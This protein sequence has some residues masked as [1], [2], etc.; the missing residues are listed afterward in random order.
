[1]KDAE[2]TVRPAIPGDGEQLLALAR[3]LAAT[4]GGMPERLT[5]EWIAANMLAADGTVSVHVAELDGRLVGYVA[6]SRMIETVYASA[7][8]YVSDLLVTA[9][10]RGRGIGRQLLAA[11][12]DHARREGREHIWLVTANRDAQRF[13]QRLANIRQEVVAFAFADET[14]A[15]LADQGAGRAGAPAIRSNEETT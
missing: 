10:V 14:F 5:R 13:Y 15:G 7:G 6:C 1:V 2:A 11:A 8:C 4:Q 9:A 3:E 12:A